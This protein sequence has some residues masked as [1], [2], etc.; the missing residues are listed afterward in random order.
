MSSTERSIS[1]VASPGA[2]G[3]ALPTQRSLGDFSEEWVLERARQQYAN[4]RARMDI[5][6]GRTALLVIDM[7]DE[8][9]KP[10]WSP[11][12]VPDAT[13]QVPTIRGVIDAFHDAELPVIFLAY[14][15]SVQGRNFP[16]TETLVP[17]GEDVANYASSILQE[18]AIFDELAPQERD[19]VVLKHCYS[20]FHG[21]ELDLVLRGLGISTLVISGTMTNFCCGA[22]AREAFWHGY[23][24]VFG[25]D[26]NST[27]DPELHDAELRTLRRGYARIMSSDE[28]ADA[29]GR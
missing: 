20:G 9:V 5:E 13:R 12:W 18:V 29:L 1:P 6:L 19:L 3:E 8:F 11:Y 23:K 14:E 17:I 28:I 4:G 24:V 26:I 7:I 10:N 25:S 2:P 15:V 16:I 21:T 22:T 27:D